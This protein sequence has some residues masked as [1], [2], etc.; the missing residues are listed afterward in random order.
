MRKLYPVRFGATMIDVGKSHIKPELLLAED[1][2]DVSRI[3]WDRA[4]RSFPK[5]TGWKD[6]WI[7]YGR[8]YEYAEVVP[9]WRVGHEDL[10][11]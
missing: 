6:H 4:L 10:P 2:E 8:G 5:R 3:L 9:V 7:D 11:N 1:D